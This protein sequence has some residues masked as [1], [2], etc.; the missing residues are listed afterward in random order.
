[1]GLPLIAVRTRQA[2]T[3]ENV[4]AAGVV[5]IKYSS[6]SSSPWRASGR[7]RRAS[8]AGRLSAEVSSALADELGGP[9]GSLLPIPNA[10]GDDPTVVALRGDIKGLRGGLAF[11][12]SQ[13]HSFGTDQESPRSG[14]DSKR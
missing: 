6:E 14:W 2:K 5:H 1:M 8:L 11:V 4:P 12:E 9:R 13:A 10:D 3:F 7:F